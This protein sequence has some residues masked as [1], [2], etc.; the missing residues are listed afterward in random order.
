MPQLGLGIQEP[1]LSQIG[2]HIIPSP[3]N[4]TMGR[5]P[6]ATSTPVMSIRDAVRCD[7]QG[8]NMAEKTALFNDSK[9][10]KKKSEL[11]P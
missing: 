11:Q 6:S 4:P 2:L 7:T 3:D 10:K 5:H 1:R 9:K 8:W